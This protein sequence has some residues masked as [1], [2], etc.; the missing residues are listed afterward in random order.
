MTKYLM[1]LCFGLA[2]SSAGQAQER[3]PGCNAD[4]INNQAGLRCMVQNELCK[5]CCKTKYPNA[6]AKTCKDAC[7]TTSNFANCQANVLKDTVSKTKQT[8]LCRDCCT[9]PAQSRTNTSELSE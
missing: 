6:K 2:F 9:P 3:Y 4:C 7:L 1:I 5:D 8:D